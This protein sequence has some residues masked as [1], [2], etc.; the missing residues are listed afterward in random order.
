M[1]ISAL[2][3]EFVFSVISFHYLKSDI[4]LLCSIR[5]YVQFVLTT[6]YFS[7]NF[8]FFLFFMKFTFQLWSLYVY[9]FLLE[10]LFVLKN[11][12]FLL[13]FNMSLQFFLLFIE[14]FIRNVILHENSHFSKLLSLYIR[15][16]VTFH[17]NCHSFCKVICFTLMFNRSSQFY[18]LDC[19][20]VLKGVI[21]CL[22][23]Y[24]S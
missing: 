17:Q 4:F 20:F 14:L 9:N 8:S 23:T 15:T 3:L 22:T 12:I 10:I 7:F 24:L 1:N 19:A 16:C 21:F 13:T 6:F 5:L 11:I 18:L 2:N